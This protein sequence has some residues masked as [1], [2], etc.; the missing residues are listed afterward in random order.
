MYPGIGYSC[1]S[2]AES[3]RVQFREDPAVLAYL[4]KRGLNPN[5]LARS[6]FEAEVRRI[7]AK[8]KFARLRARDIRL[9]ASGASLIREIR[10]SE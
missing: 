2:M 8:E 10:D 3:G 9:P 4:E 5:E 6:A 7:R 1:V